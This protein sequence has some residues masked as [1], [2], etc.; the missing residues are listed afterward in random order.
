[1]T[2]KSPS[3]QIQFGGGAPQATA[4]NGTRYFDTSNLAGGTLA[5][6]ICVN[7]VWVPCGTGGVGILPNFATVAALVAAFPAAA[8]LKGWKS[9]VSD[10]N[11]TFTA[12]IGAIVAGGGA[13]VV[14][15]F[16][17][18]ANWRIG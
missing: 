6:Y 10:A 8:A 16:C 2:T 13:N 14:P 9:A 17:D 4:P 11:A 7:G 18:G 1:M 15:V 5:E 12:G 3:P